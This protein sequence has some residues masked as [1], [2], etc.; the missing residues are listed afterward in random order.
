MS[1]R[2]LNLLFQSLTRATQ[3]SDILL[4][5]EEILIQLVQVCAAFTYFTLY[6]QIHY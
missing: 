6:H 4:K 5:C 1:L 3:R 2:P